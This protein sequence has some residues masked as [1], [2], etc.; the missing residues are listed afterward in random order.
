MSYIHSLTDTWTDSGTTYKGISMDVTDTASAAES[1]LISLLVGGTEK[2]G[3]SKTGDSIFTGAS[4]TPAS[5]SDT[6]IAGQICWDS[7]YIYVCTATNTW[8][9]VAIATW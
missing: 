4:K 5:A 9:R 3:V 6:G 1:R 8:K 2:F 7:S